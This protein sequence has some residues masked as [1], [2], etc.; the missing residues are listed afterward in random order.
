M[1][2]FTG[3]K[4][5]HFIGIGG[6]GMSAMAEVMYQQGFVV[7]GSDMEKSEMTDYLASL[8]IMVMK[9]HKEGQDS[10]ADVVI[11]SSAVKNDNPELVAARKRGIPTAKRAEALAEIMKKKWTLAVSGS[12]GKTTTTFMLSSIWQT[13]GLEPTVIGGG[14]AQGA[15]SGAIAGKGDYLIAEA[16]EYDH[17]FLSMYPTFTI[18]NNIDDDHLDCYGSLEKVKDAFVEYTR[19]TPF[20]GIVAVNNDDPGVISIK[21]R[22]REATKGM[23][24]SFGFTK[25]ADYRAVEP[26]D[27]TTAGIF[28]IEC[29]AGCFRVNLSLSGHHNISNALGAFAISHALGLAPETIV[30]GLDNF[31]GV[32]RRMELVGN[33]NGVS[34]Y[35]DYAHHPA[36]VSASLEAMDQ[37][38]GERLVVVFQPH[39]FSRTKQ[40]A[41]SFA[42]AL[43]ACD[44][45][46]VL[47]VYAAREKPIEG[48]DG[49]LIADSAKAF[50]HESI[51]YLP[52]KSVWM[53]EISSRLQ[54]GD[55]LVT[56]GAGDVWKLGKAV[57]NT[58]KEG[59]IKI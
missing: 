58:L 22:L 6:A 35:D 51:Y 37:I 39:L 48:V 44:V 3:F 34:I 14:A 21:A 23:F 2:P 5:V 41:K 38:K 4:K 36:E 43:Q 32:R 29:A 18:I 55:T 45:L 52:D 40:H 20:C 33:T 8:G 17:S 54:P 28:D 16:D 12:H 49:Y 31:N 25:E 30:Q 47:P 53:D 15:I 27:N 1:K 9:G 24:I 11:Y 10:G 46:F 56:M 42:S 13:A 50:G 57:M 19:R 59:V 7:T 26:V